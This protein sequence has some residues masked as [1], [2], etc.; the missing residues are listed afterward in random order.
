MTLKLIEECKFT[1]YDC[2]C[3]SPIGRSRFRWLRKYPLF[4]S[5]KWAPVKNPKKIC[6]LFIEKSEV[7]R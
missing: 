1:C 4:C 7:M 3:S 5:I 6:S 2:A